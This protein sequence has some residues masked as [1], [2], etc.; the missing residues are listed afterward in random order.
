MIQNQ[1]LNLY[2]NTYNKIYLS[3]GDSAGQSRQKILHITKDE[4]N[5]DKI[6]RHRTFDGNIS[7]LYE[8]SKAKL[9]S[10]FEQ[11]N[12]TVRNSKTSSIHQ[13]RLNDH[14]RQNISSVLVSARPQN[15]GRFPNKNLCK[16][17]DSCLIVNNNLSLLEGSFDLAN[18][19]DNSNMNCRIHDMNYFGLKSDMNLVNIYDKKNAEVISG[20]SIDISHCKSVIILNK[21]KI[22]S[23]SV[24]SD[25]GQK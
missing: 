21:S 1:E 19:F 18:G 22:Q 15:F 24:G 16:K 7:K 8:H 11:S 25:S 3:Q 5:P 17:E 20:K 4:V 14:L 9:N 6:I 13:T 10:M 23:R 2:K 12:K